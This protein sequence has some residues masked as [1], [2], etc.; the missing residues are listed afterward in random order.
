MSK[1]LIL[2]IAI[3]WSSNASSA[4]TAGNILYNISMTETK[5]DIKIKNDSGEEVTVYNARSGRSYRL[6]R[7]AITT[8][9]MQDDDKLFEY[10]GG[11]IGRLLLTASAALAGKIQLYSKL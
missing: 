11:K 10:K 7:N 5:Y 9:K 8:I 6:I 1:I 4:T 3:L 2:V